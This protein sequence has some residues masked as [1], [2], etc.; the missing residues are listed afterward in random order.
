MG[1]RIRVG[2]ITVEV[3][4]VEGDRICVGVMAPEKV[5]RQIREREEH[6]SPKPQAPWEVDS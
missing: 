5:L 3:V 6:V 2:D 4:S 1:D